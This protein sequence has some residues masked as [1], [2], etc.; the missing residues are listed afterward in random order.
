MEDGQLDQLD[1]V[2]TEDVKPES[3]GTSRSGPGASS[4]LT[5]KRKQSGTCSICRN[6]E[7][8]FHFSI[9][10]IKETKQLVQIKTGRTLSSL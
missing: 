5:I 7:K 4:V 9:Y 2:Q 1:S 10:I 3:T 6:L 8:L